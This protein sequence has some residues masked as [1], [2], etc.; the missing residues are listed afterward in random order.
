M[1]ANGQLHALAAL[2]AGKECPAPTEYQAGWAP[3]SVWT[4]WRRENSLAHEGSP[5]TAPQSS[6]PNI[7]IRLSYPC[8]QHENLHTLILKICVKF[9]LDSCNNMLC[10]KYTYDYRNC[11]ILKIAWNLTKQRNNYKKYVLQLIKIS[12]HNKNST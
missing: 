1:E 6:R 12:F 9:S 10:S 8:S 4:L 11:K 7:V 5:S 2:P 3:Q